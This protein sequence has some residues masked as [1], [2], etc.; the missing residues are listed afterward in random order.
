GEL[1]FFQQSSKKAEKNLTNLSWR[2]IFVLITLF[3]LLKIG[4]LSN[5]SLYTDPS[6]KGMV[7]TYG[8]R[9]YSLYLKVLP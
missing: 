2:C 4:G 3:G 7:W 5:D 9:T 8:W 6:K 1:P